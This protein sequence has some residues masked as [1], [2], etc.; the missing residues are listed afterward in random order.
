MVLRV[1]IPNTARTMPKC[2]MSGGDF[3]D[4]A[5]KPGQ[6]GTKG[7]LSASRALFTLLSFNFKPKH[8]DNPLHPKLPC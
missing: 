2:G 8:V 6:E 5:F 4:K 1:V 3:N 7:A